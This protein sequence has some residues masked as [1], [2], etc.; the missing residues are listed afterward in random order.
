MTLDTNTIF[1]LVID[2]HDIIYVQ[3]NQI[4]YIS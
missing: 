2:T 1:I 3:I 4:K